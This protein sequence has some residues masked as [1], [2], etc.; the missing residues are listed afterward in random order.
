MS[1]ITNRSTELFKY[2]NQF[3]PNDVISIISSYCPI[4][5][6]KMPKTL[7]GNKINTIIGLTNDRFA[8]G[9]NDGNVSI[10]NLLNNIILTKKIDKSPISEICQLDENI[11]IGGM[12]K[13]QYIFI[14]DFIHNTLRK[15]KYETEGCFNMIVLNKDS[16][17]FIASC[18]LYIVN[19]KTNKIKRISSSKTPVICASLMNNNILFGLGM[20]EYYRNMPNDIIII[21]CIKFISKVCTV[22]DRKLLELE[23]FRTPS[24]IIPLENNNI[25]IVETAKDSDDIITVREIDIYGPIN[26]INNIK[27]KVS[28]VIYLGNNHIVVLI[29]RKVLI[30]NIITGE[31]VQTFKQKKQFIAVVD[32]KIITVDYNSNIEVYK[33]LM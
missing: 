23:D 14:W 13:E 5:Y 33:K 8:T 29:E 7:K 20:C 19:L 24:I 10:Y 21:N 22:D 11:I 9:S 32:D 6:N 27:G 25:I 31:Q 16:V 3:F 1:H 26:I 2:L 18:C 12:L 15:I 4:Y 28:K 30:F 17:V